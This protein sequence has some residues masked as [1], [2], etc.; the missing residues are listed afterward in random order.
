[1][2]LLDVDEATWN[3]LSR[4]LDEALD[5]PAEE[6][7][8]W[9]AS[10]PEAAREMGPRLRQLLGPAA[11]ATGGSPLDALPRMDLGPTT[12]GGR[13]GGPGAHPGELVGPYRLIQELA[14]GGMGTVWLAERADGMVQRQ[15]ALKLPRGAWQGAALAERMGREREI[16]ATLEHPHIARLY[17]AGVTAEGQPW[18]ALEYVEGR[19][20][21]AYL[22]QE[23]PDLRRRLALFLQV[24]SAVAHAHARLVV[25]RDLK[26]SNILVTREGQ[27]RLLDFGIAKLLDQGRAQ[28]TELTRLGGR[29][30]TPGYASPEQIR[31]EPLGVASDVYSLGVVL[32][33]MLAGARPYR[34][35]RESAAALEEAILTA[36]PARPS[37][38]AAEPAIRKALRGDLETVVL[39]ALKKRP[40]ERYATANALAED[41]ERWLA[42]RPVAAQPDSRAYRL[43]KLVSRNAVAVGASAAVALAVLV[44]SGV[45]LWQARTALAEKRRA[46]EVK[47]FIASIFREADPFGTQGKALS[48]AELLHRARARI[49]GVD[50]GRPELRVEL[51]D[52][53]G[54]SLLGLGDTDGA[55]AVARQALGEASRLAP[56]H[57]QALRARLLATDVARVR[58]RTPEMRQELDRLV[59]ALRR[60]AAG[61]PEELIR[62]LEN[63]AHLAIDETRFE[64]AVAAAQEAFDLARARLGPRDPRTVD[65]SNLLAESHQYETDD[66]GVA[67]A[68]AERGLRLALDAYRDQRMHPR[69]IAMREVYARSLSQAGQDRRA[70][71]EWGRALRE[72]REVFG[73]NSPLAGE[74]AANMLPG[75]RRLGDVRGAL[76][77]ATEAIEALSHHAQADSRTKA[78]ALVGRG[79]T[80]LLARRGAEAL[81]DLSA[82]TE[83]LVRILGPENGDALTARLNRGLALAYAGRTGEARAELDATIA[84]YRRHMPEY[85]MYAHH[86]LGAAQRLAGSRREALRAQEQA[87]ALIADGGLREWNRLRVLAELGLAQA[88]AGKPGEALRSEEE[89]LALS[90][91]LQ[92]HDS[93]LRADALLGLGRAYAGLG[94][95]A[96]GLAPLEEADRFWRDFDPRSRWA[97]EAALWLG[98]CYTA[99]GRG[100]EAR[101]ALARAEAIL[102]RSPIPSDATLAARVRRR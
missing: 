54:Q 95:A 28:E 25:H 97:G 44:G 68:A 4:L 87:L 32:Y 100:P 39:K 45:S 23:R 20:V 98:Q 5:L 37:E 36:E 89:A 11:L 24:A 76:E 93:P 51:L 70:V 79:V 72:A 92:D 91:R 88:D 10:L 29:A 57:L 60:R 27:A 62:A 15:V 78:T 49:D 21:D 67:L 73:P 77:N 85:L 17:D 55:E 19:P 63:R 42:G 8:E 2:A 66:P 90:R 3:A 12:A 74:I 16:L 38:V 30:L 31:G 81:A 1:M 75:Q 96:E 52:L 26:P 71:D 65:A 6:R 46:E 35:P 61:A 59:P 84:L 83:T 47:E 101:R 94:R 56:E 102:A 13:A 99:L 14:Q 64:E 22:D 86:V 48:A 7:E 82:A 40:E 69:V 9:L 80:W 33:Q 34:L 53:L 43:R 58:G 50:P 41:V 18:L